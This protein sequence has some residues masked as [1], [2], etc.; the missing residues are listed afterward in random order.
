MGGSVSPGDLE[1]SRLT[2]NTIK[3]KEKHYQITP[4]LGQMQASIYLNK[5]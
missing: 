2:G 1:H 4:A 3:M 5:N